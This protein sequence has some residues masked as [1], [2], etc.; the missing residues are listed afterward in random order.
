MAELPT[1]TVTLLFTDIEGSTRLLE[2]LGDR[3]V[4]VLGDHRQLLRAAFTEFNG[5]EVG[6]DGDAFFVAFSRANEAVAAAVAAQQALSD[7]RWPDG[8]RLQV[9]MGIHT[10]EP[11]M[12][13]DD[14]AGMD[15]HRAARTCA[16]GHGGQ[17]LLSQVSQELLGDE[18]PTGVELRDLGEHRLKD[19]TDPQRLYQL[20]D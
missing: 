14:Y 10:G 8:T 4:A 18:L 6:T 20:D 9:R 7:H 2:R 15:V 5:H 17:V 19:L 13:A 1:G 3:Y 16:A 12:V 11:I